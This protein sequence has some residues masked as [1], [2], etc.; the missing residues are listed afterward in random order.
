MQ[1]YLCMCVY[2]LHLPVS[3]YPLYRY[4]LYPTTCVPAIPYT[5]Y[6]IPCTPYTYPCTPYTCTL[7]HTLY[8]TPVPYTLPYLYPICTCILYPST[9]YLHPVPVRYTCTLY[10]C[11]LYLYPIQVPPIS[12]LCAVCIHLSTLYPPSPLLSH[13]SHLIPPH[14]Y[15]HENNLRVLPESFGAVQVGGNL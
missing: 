12:S 4:T 8:T 1:S 6:P 15:L 3:L 9:L 10:T 14:R 2:V 13:L 11:T 7:Y 5:L